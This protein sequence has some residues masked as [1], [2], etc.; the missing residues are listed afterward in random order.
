[1]GGTAIPSFGCDMAVRRPINW[2]YPQK[3]NAHKTPRESQNTGSKALV[4]CQQSSFLISLKHTLS[5]CQTAFS[6]YDVDGASSHLKSWRAL[7]W[8]AVGPLVKNQGV[9]ELMS[10]IDRIVNTWSVPHH[11]IPHSTPDNDPWTHNVVG[12]DGCWT[13]PATTTG[14]L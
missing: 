1:V 11:A 12:R 14:S 10:S 7:V 13:R 2:A 4:L 8:I 3:C 9:K 6:C 5:Y